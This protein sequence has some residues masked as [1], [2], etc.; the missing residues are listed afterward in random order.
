[1]TKSPY[2]V[3]EAYSLGYWL[4]DYGFFPKKWALYNYMDHGMTFFDTI[5]AHEIENNAPFI[6]KFSPR[7]VEEYKKVSKTMPV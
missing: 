1:M 5:P 3:T 7:L 4:K 2:W 6:F